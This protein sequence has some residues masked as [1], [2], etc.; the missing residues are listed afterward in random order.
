MD[1]LT[2]VDDAVERVLVVAHN[3]GLFELVAR[4]TP[5]GA[6]GVLHAGFPPA[7]YARFDITGPVRLAGAA[8]AQL[9]E[10]R[11]PASG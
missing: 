8:P 4:L 6:A 2:E 5:D 7:S 3:P 9:L 1:R 11:R 10:I